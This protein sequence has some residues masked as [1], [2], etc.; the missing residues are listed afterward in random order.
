MLILNK[1]YINYYFAFIIN[2]VQLVV[3][4]VSCACVYGDN[5]V[6]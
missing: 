6:A 3:W 2:Q 4:L 1:K 5:S